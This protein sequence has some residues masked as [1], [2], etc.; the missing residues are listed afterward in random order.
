MQKKECKFAITSL[1]AHTLRK[2]ENIDYLIWQFIFHILLDSPEHEWFKNHMKSGELVF[3]IRANTRHMVTK[4]LN[5]AHQVRTHTHNHTEIMVEWK[6][7]LLIKLQSWFI[8]LNLNSLSSMADLF[9]A[10][11]SMSFENHSLN[12]SCESN[13]VGMMKCRRAQSWGWSTY[14]H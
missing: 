2:G 13:K 3:N 14:Y 1:M 5:T 11:L 10:W 9:S 8:F 6:K 12:S 7:H 4:A